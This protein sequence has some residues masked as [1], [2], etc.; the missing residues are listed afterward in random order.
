MNE[1]KK[2][3]MLEK[4]KFLKFNTLEHLCRVVTTEYSI[5]VSKGPRKD[6]RLNKSI[7]FNKK[8]IQSRRKQLLEIKKKYNLNIDFNSQEIKLYKQIKD[9]QKL[10]KE[11]YE[12]KKITG[13][14]EFQER[15]KKA[16]LKLIEINKI[17]TNF[18]YFIT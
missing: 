7:E 16:A 15:Q 2:K 5:S 17:L 3:K 13:R 4:I 6:D 10:L 8:V 9:V 14:A 11:L 12:I 1:I 18:N